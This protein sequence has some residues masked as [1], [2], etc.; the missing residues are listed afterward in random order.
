[1]ISPSI[2]RKARVSSLVA[3][4]RSCCHP[5]LCLWVASLEQRMTHT[6]TYTKAHIHTVDDP[7]SAQMF[8]TLANQHALNVALYDKN[9]SLCPSWQA[10]PWQAMSG[11]CW[12]FSTNKY[13]ICHISLDH[14]HLDTSRFLRLLS[15]VG[16]E[17]R[18][19][20]GFCILPLEAFPAMQ[21]ASGCKWPEQPAQ[22]TIACRIRQA[23][24]SAQA[25]ANKTCL[26]DFATTCNLAWN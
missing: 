14:F 26:H 16:G 8:T 21:R 3:D 11:L 15:L 1:M 7:C 25:T 20:L 4:S 9:I 12:L 2:T 19:R 23:L 24:N 17:E 5:L 18:E 13:Q 22:T 10:R 6:R